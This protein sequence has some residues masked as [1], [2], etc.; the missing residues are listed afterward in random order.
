MS[1][2]KDI[3]KHSSGKEVLQGSDF[4]H[5]SFV[6]SNRD[7]NTNKFLIEQ[8]EGSVN[9]N[10]GAVAHPMMK[11]KTVSFHSQKLYTQ[12]DKVE[13]KNSK[14]NKKKRKK[15]RCHKADAATKLL[16]FNRFAGFNF[17]AQND[18]DFNY[19]RAENYEGSL[20]KKIEVKDCDV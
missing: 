14:G 6:L 1:S 11:K 10:W 9:P 7:S 20:V 3:S 4:T 8:N 5:N 17:E 15:G 13:G 2:H 12:L 18:Y 16:G 19:F